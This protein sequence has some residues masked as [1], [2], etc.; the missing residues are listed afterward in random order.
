ML[1]FLK[2]LL[3][4]GTENKVSLTFEEVPAYLDE[5][6]RNAKETLL[7]EVQEPMRAIKNALAGLQLTVN[8]LNGADQNPETHPKIKSIA[9]NSLPLFLKAMNSSL[10]KEL[11]DDPEE[12][13]AAA[14]ENVKGCLN[15][16]RGQGRYLQ[17]VFPDEMKATKAGID[18]VGHEINTMTK[19]LGRYRQQA[20]RIAAVRS[21]HASLAAAK[22]DIEHS[23]GKEE[24]LRTRIAEIS[25]R[26]EAITQETARLQADPS[27]T[28]LDAERER[29]AGLAREREECLRHYVSLSMTMSHVFRKAEKIAVKK[30]LSKE[31]HILKD[32]MEILSDHEVAAADSCCRAL[33]AAGPVAGKMIADGEI[34]LKNKEERL[35]FSDFTH[36]S[37]EVAGLCTRFHALEKECRDVEEGLLSH[38]VLS[39]LEALCREK[40][41]L[42][43][44]R[45]REEQGL[46][47]LLEWRKKS[48]GSV[49]DLRA[50]LVKKLED[51]AGETVQFR[52]DEPV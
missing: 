14:V 51:M 22:G 11:P 1:K 8:N 32:A 18:A 5:R 38:P 46:V 29:S 47:E 27:L 50:D 36:C 43:G 39:R 34:V 3:G 19:A 37:G 6:E 45:V 23:H 35:I 49:P 44:M 20:G 9:K 42:E 30:H 17:V 31:V 7:A 40:E 25:G 21:A 41:Q 12:F 52:M 24:R 2:S 16:M 26:L 10:A 4:S 33:A 28:T 15:A 13:Y 48:V